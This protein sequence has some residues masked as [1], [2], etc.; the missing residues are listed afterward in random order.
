MGTFTAFISTLTA[1]TGT[2]MASTILTQPK[3][4]LMGPCKH[5][6]AFAT[7]SGPIVALSRAIQALS[8]PLLALLW[9]LHALSRALQTLSCEILPTFL[10]N[11]YFY[12][13]YSSK[14]FL[15]GH[16]RAFKGHE[17]AFRGRDSAFRGR[18]NVCKVRLRGRPCWFM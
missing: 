12:C 3:L 11:I 13:S 16:E 10:Q 4:I 6:H 7:V 18:E 5:S 1:T 14:T 15:K 9:P 2:F 8:L 17:S